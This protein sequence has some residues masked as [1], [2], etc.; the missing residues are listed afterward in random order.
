MHLID[1]D[2]AA[3][4]GEGS[5]SLGCLRRNIFGQAEFNSELRNSEY[6]K[7]TP[8]GSRYGSQIDWQVMDKNRKDNEN[9]GNAIFTINSH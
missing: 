6:T 7:N 9:Y 2:S 1:S 5:S 8:S 4:E 3:L